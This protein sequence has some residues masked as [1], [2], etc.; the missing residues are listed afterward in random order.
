MEMIRHNDVNKQKRTKS[1]SM[2][3]KIML[4]MSGLAMLQLV[5]FVGILAASGGFSYIRSYS[6]NIVSEKTENRKSYVESALT[7][8]TALV[9]EISIEVNEITER[10]LE[11]RGLTVA[12]IQKDEDLNAQILSECAGGLLSLIRRDMVNDAYIILDSGTLYDSDGRS[13][14]PGL[15]MRDTDVKENSISDNADIFMEM[16]SSKVAREYGLALDTDWSLLL[17]VT[18][19]DDGNFDFFFKPLNTYADS[20]DMEREI[21]SM[22]YWSTLSRISEYQQES[23]KYS[24]PLVTKDGEVYGVIGIGLMK[25]TIQA[26]IPVNDFFNESACYILGVDLEGSGRYTPVIYSGAL[27]RRLVSENTVLG[28]D[29]PKEYGLWDFTVPDGMK[30]CGSIQRMNL[31]NSGSPYRSE[32][33][34]L[35]SVVDENQILTIYYAVLHAVF[36]SVLFAVA[37][38]ITFAVFTSRRISRPVNLMVRTLEASRERNQPVEFQSSGITEIDVLASSIIDLQKAVAEYA[39]KA[40]DD[41]YM[42]KLLEANATLKDAYAAAK[43]ANNAKTDF[44]SR[45][46]HDIRT[47]MNAIIGM[48]TI[49]RAYLHD[50]EKISDCLE[51]ITVSG[52]FLLSLINEVLDMSKIESGKLVLAK[53]DINLLELVDDLVEMVRPSV[54]DK[55]HKLEVHVNEVEHKYVIGD[56]LRIQ[57][58]F[59]NFM[60]NAVK[61]TPK[62]GH[63]EI[64]IS[65]KTVNQSKVGCYEFIFE[66]NGTGMAPEFMEKIFDPFERA[67]DTRVNKEQGTGLGMAI[68]Y[69]IVRMMDGD[70]RVESEVGKGTRFT[71][72]IFLQLQ[73]TEASGWK[74]PESLTGDDALKPQ[75]SQNEVIDHIKEKNFA[76][77]RALLVDDNELNREVAAEILG[78]TGIAVEM[79]ED[80][81]EA[82]ERFSASEAGYYDVILMD[83]QMPVMNGY[84]ATKAIRRLPRGDALSV[85]IVAMTA[86]AFAEDARAAKEA[87]MDEHIAKPLDLYKLFEVLNQW[88]GD[89]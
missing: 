38:G 45:M 53:E 66:D 36:I 7:Q 77:R 9:Y 49:A 76:G 87:G 40:K 14:R 33:W 27:Y 72:T 51:K 32:Q 19:Q 81:Q 61:Y 23:I 8:K 69:N 41:E 80:G 6:Y 57:Q 83:V 75:A 52:R 58:V 42:S 39:A 71:V 25:K 10:I 62:G 30:C 59:M 13:M 89:V 17:D 84:E 4:P 47:P 11:E 43:R 34:A 88:L 21:Y 64:T 54:R 74:E 46:S 22:G 2:L 29:R 86:N 68:A 5:F 37:I 28:T 3:S 31:Y 15:Y 44:L 18:E 79:A 48:T 55:K 82:V 20:R 35:I 67:D 78:M 56:R 24:L 16:G 65:E 12:D 73:E 26:S 60:S 1:R 63:I 85:P 70:I 50:P